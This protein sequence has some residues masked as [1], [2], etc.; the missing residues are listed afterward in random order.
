MSETFDK[1]LDSG[2][3]IRD[4]YFECHGV[5]NV[6]VYV[7]GKMV[8]R[9]ILIVPSDRSDYVLMDIVV[10]DTESRRNG[11]GSE[12]MKYLTETYSPMITGYRTVDGR[13]LCMKHGFKLKPKFF[14]REIDTLR[15]DREEAQ[16]AQ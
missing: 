8:G 5:H 1:H 4:E 14:A 16:G 3:M 15:Y 13:E 7:K 12:M 10:F 9:A 6:G 11:L 2:H